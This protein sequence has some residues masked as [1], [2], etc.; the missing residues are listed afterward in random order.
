MFQNALVSVSDKRGLADFLNQILS[1]NSRIV[2]TGG[3]AN[4]LSK[5]NLAVTKVEDWTGHPEVMDGRVKTLHPR[6][7]MSLLYRQEDAEL[8]KSSNLEPFDL[9]IGNLY[10]FPEK[11]SVETID[12]GGPSFLRAS[13]KNFMNVIV[14]CDPDDYKWLAEKKLKL[15]LEERKYLAAK[16]F[17]HLS[18]YDATVASWLEEQAEPKQFAQWSWGGSIQQRLRYGENPHQTG[19]W[20]APLGGKDSFAQ[21]EQLQGKQLSYNN[22]SD[23]EAAIKCL[24]LFPSEPTAVAVKHN[25]PCGVASSDTLPD[26][27]TKCLAA[28]PKSVFGGIIALNGKVDAAIATELSELFLECVIAPEILPDAQQV[29][30]KKG[31]LRV[32]QWPHW[33]QQKA[34]SEFRSA[35]GGCL[36]QS[37]DKVADVWNDDWQTHGS[38]PTEDQKADLLFAWKVCSA[39]KSN[40]ISICRNRQSIGLGMGQV[41]RVD[42]VA[43]AIQ[44]ANDFHGSLEGAVLASDAFFPFEDSIEIIKKAGIQWAIQPGGSVRDEKVISAAKKLDVNLILTGQRHFNH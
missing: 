27:V 19:F 38:K 15:S 23:L 8:L 33:L 7:H 2:S 5:Q 3:T 12:V 4:F 31:N 25:N 35:L 11:P 34:H 42:A 28:D 40:A 20:V 39:L 29:F 36:V 37:L 18:A 32:L 14:V 22:L 6:I 13:A 10:P 9:V 17:R 41:N 44:R 26:A 43:H 21:A 16:V 1:P 30:A 24:R